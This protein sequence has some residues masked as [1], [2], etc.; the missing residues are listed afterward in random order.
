[1]TYR[2]NILNL[3]AKGQNSWNETAVCLLWMNFGALIYVNSI[4]KPMTHSCYASRQSA[5]RRRILG[6]EQ[7]TYCIVLKPCIVMLHGE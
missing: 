7:A 6:S 1:M 5:E 2:L 3:L 4:L